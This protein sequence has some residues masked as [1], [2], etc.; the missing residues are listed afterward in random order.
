M[1]TVYD[2]AT[3]EKV[4]ITV[5]RKETPA[6]RVGSE[7]ILAVVKI[8]SALS[9]R[10]MAVRLG[11]TP[12]AVEKQIAKLRKDGRLKRIGPAKGGHW[13]VVES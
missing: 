12:R 4:S 11:I 13:D 3:N 6:L 8:E 2:T 7:K 9:A 1:D 5:H 10:Q